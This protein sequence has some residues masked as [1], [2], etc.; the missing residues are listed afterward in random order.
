MIVDIDQIYNEFSAGV[1][2]PLA[3]RSFLKR[4]YYNWSERPVYVMFLGDGSYDFRNIYNLQTKNYLPSMQKSDITINEINSFP[5]DDFVTNIND[6]AS[7]V[8]AVKP[9]FGVGRICA[10]SLTDANN[11][12]D[13]I[14]KYENPENNGLWKKKIMYV[15]DDGWTTSNPGGEGS[16]HTGQCEMVAEFYTPQDFEKEKIYIVNYP[17]VIT[18][19]GRRKPQAN[20]D[21]VRGWNEGRLVVNYTGHGSADLWAHEQI[22]ERQVSIPQL[23]NSKRYPLVTI[24]SCDLA[25]YDDP[26]FPSW[27]KS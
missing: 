10:N 14:E 19:Q 13:K 27:R 5:V 2:D 23:N 17:T 21:I 26:F 1:M 20:I 22:F 24:A 4:A 12:I 18:A 11:Y 8:Q 15:A 9:D 3:V 7:L 25:R 6:T 16:L